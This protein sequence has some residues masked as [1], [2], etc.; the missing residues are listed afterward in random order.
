MIANYHTHTPRCGHAVGSEREYIERAI[1]SGIEILGF[2]D[3]APYRFDRPGKY[4]GVRMEPE[5]LPDYAET[6]FTL[7]NEYAGRIELHLGVEAEY[8]PLYFS[9]LVD[10]LRANG[11][12]YMILGQHFLGNEIGEPGSMAAT[13]DPAVLDRYVSQV[14]EGIETGLFS[15]I[16]HPD[17]LRFEGDPAEYDRG[18]RRICVRARELGIPLE[19]NLLGLKNGRH[20]PNESFWRIAGEEGNAVILGSDAHRPEDVW[21]PETELSALSLVNKY[22]LHLIDKAELRR[23]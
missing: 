12:E 5:M 9:S 20:Y 6:F 1:E 19:I 11:V 16:A 2:S 3:H 8:Y 22:S 17:V 14:I 7:R 15:Y 13:T 10:D 4:P 23:I 18:C 21:V